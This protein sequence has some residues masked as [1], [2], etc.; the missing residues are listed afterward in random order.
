MPDDVRA[1]TLT[2]EPVVLA[3]VTGATSWWWADPATMLALIVTGLLYAQ[4][5]RALATHRSREVLLP[6]WR[7]RC[8]HAGLL[9]LV[10]ALAGPVDAVAGELFWVHMVQHQLLALVAPPLLILGRSGLVIGGA[11][12]RPVR[13]ILLP[14][15]WLPRALRSGAVAAAGAAAVHAGTWWLWHLPGPYEAALRSDAAHV[16]EHVLFLGSGAVL[17]S[18]TLRRRPRVGLPVALLSVV[19]AMLP[20][21]ALAAL[22]TFST[23]SWYDGHHAADWG[24]TPLEDQQLGGALMWFPGSLSYLAVAAVIVF[25]G[26]TP[27]P[28]PPCPP[29]TAG[30]GRRPVDLA[31]GQEAGAGPVESRTTS[32]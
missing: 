15:R 31:A 22:L 32:R 29:P 7:V 16:A 23:R 8:F 13:R 11:L 18:V 28:A 5:R 20:T 6:R 25:R 17:W 27:P 1:P 10:A 14:G 30:A 3:H 4:G 2:V 9:V 12:P 21:S 19:A 24:L 26:L